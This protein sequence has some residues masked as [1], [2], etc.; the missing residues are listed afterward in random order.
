MQINLYKFPLDKQIG[1][2]VLKFHHII[3]GNPFQDPRWGEVKMK[4]FKDEEISYL[5]IGRENN[6]ISFTALLI[7]RKYKF[8]FESLRCERGPI[9][10]NF[11]EKI[12]NELIDFIKKDNEFSK[13]I[14]FE[15]FPNNTWINNIKLIQ[16]IDSIKFPAYSLILDLTKQETILKSEM[17]QKCRYNLNKA[18]KNPDI[19]IKKGSIDLL[20]DYVDL[21]IKTN[22]RQGFTS[23][24]ME[25]FLNILDSFKED[26]FIVMAYYGKNPISGGIFVF[27]G[28]LCT[29]YVGASDY[30]YRNL[31][32]TYLVQWEAISEAYKRGC[33]KYDFLGI[34]P[35]P[36]LENHDLE[37]V[38][39]FKK[40][41]GGNIVF[42]GYPQI[43][44]LK[45]LKYYLFKV[46]KKIR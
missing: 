41:F 12:F 8:G 45:K 9:F 26:A 17:D 16:N 4:T 21:S 25:Y 29:Y 30:N 19:T 34:S 20:Q 14:S 6:E 44:V 11:N 31:M 36:H 33:K 46:L 40:S 3:G 2:D 37:G 38:T 39:R 18:S 42:Q 10:R 15:I 13:C 32:S 24:N 43:F 22:K 28:D 5:L 23:Q 1:S 27:S 35:P 7:K